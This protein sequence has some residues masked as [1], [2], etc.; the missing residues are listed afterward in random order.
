MAHRTSSLV[1][2]ATELP[3]L[4]VVV[5]LRLMAD[6]W[7]SSSIVISSDT[8]ITD[9]RHIFFLDSESD[10]SSIGAAGS[11]VW[12]VRLVSTTFEHANS[13]DVADAYLL[14]VRTNIIYYYDRFGHRRVHAITVSFT[15]YHF[16]SFFLDLA[17]LDA[18]QWPGIGWH[19]HDVPSYCFRRLSTPL[20]FFTVYTGLMPGCYG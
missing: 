4:Y 9:T 6:G 8:S 19:I 1:A 17:A 20:G 18:G 11:V 10:S 13:S 2:F 16:N 15:R 7:F 12:L 3:I 5:L 14:S